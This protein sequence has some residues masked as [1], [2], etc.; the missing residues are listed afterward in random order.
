MP[1]L[2]P[3]QGDMLEEVCSWARW[4]FQVT[5]VDLLLVKLVGL[6]TSFALRFLWCVYLA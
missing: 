6:R 2:D 1:Y 4:S 3:R 5:L